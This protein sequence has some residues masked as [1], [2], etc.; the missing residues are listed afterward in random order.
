MFQQLFHFLAS[1][2]G[3]ESAKYLEL[4]CKLDKD[5]KPT[6]RRREDFRGLLDVDSEE[7]VAFR[8]RKQSGLAVVTEKLDG[9]ILLSIKGKNYKSI[10]DHCQM[11]AF[12]YR[13]GIGLLSLRGK[14]QKISYNTLLFSSK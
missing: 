10:P 8:F 11:E 6:L 14:A 12:V 1:H 4:L 7:M 3:E 2:E 5:Q 9:Q 13:P